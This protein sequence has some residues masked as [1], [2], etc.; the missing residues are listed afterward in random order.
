MSRSDKVAL[1]APEIIY[2]TAWKELLTESCVFEAL[3]N[4][5]RAIDTANQRQHYYE[6][7]VGAAL[8][9]AYSQLGLKRS[10]IFLQTKFTYAR[11]QDHRKPYDENAPF[12]EQVQQSFESSLVHLKTD[13]IDSLVLHG[14][15]NANGLADADWEVWGA[16]EKICAAGKIKYLGISNVNYDQ[17]F[18]LQRK[19]NIQPS[20]VQNRCFADKHWDK[21]IRDFCKL[22][23][24]RYQGFSLLTANWKY[25]GGEVHRPTERNIPQLVFSDD[26]SEETGLHEKIEEIIKQTGKTIPQII[27]RF[28][29][30][31]GIIPVV[32]TRS[33]EH[34]KLDLAVDDFELSQNQLQILEN[35]AFLKT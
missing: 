20:F 26:V 25:L 22:E 18:E 14:P 3:K 24:I 8:T 1:K 30:Q 12:A 7:G 16:L 17:L 31:I 19:A 10:D 13:Y 15:A 6:E 35:V 2:G 28:V 33:P 4:G 21:K 5:F 29:R 34:M 27:I 11:G 23:G 32:G 9:K